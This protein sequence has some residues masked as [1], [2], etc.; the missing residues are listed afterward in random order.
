[1]TARRSLCAA[2]PRVVV[3]GRAVRHRLD[4]LPRRADPGVPGP[5][6]PRGRRNRLL[7]RLDLLHHRGHPAAAGVGARRSR[8]AGTGLEILWQPHNRDWW[9]SAVQWV[10]TLFFNATTFRGLTTAIDSPSYN[11]LVWRPDA[12]GSVCF[13]VSGWL[14]YVVVVG[15]IMRRPHGTDGAIAARQPVRLRGVRCD[16]P[17]RLRDPGHPAAAGRPPRER[18]P[19]R[20]AAWPSCRCTAAPPADAQ[21]RTG[22]RRRSVRDVGQPCPAGA[23]TPSRTSSSIQ[24][25]VAISRAAPSRWSSTS[26][27]GQV[28]E[29]LHEPDQSLGQLDEPGGR[30]T[31]AAGRVRPATRSAI[32]SPT[33][34]PTKQEHESAWSLGDLQRVE[35]VA[36]GLDV[37]GVRA[38]AG[39]DGA[40]VEHDPATAYVVQASA[41]QAARARAIAGAAW[42]IRHR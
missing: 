34:R 40:E 22:G 29:V 21:R 30:A 27:I 19:R 39:D 10:G 23:G 13:L 4:V 8:H 2:T 36:R 5:R 11:Q 6:G 17:G 38:R 7:R 33:V 1:M 14:A 26:T 9:S 31:A 16:R 41:R 3:D 18:S 25:T 20:S 12:Y 32:T 42:S 28:G 37:A 24:V 15:G 35:P